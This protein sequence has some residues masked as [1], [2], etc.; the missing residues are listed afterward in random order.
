[1]GDVPR[2]LGLSIRAD[3]LSRH[4]AFT[5]PS[6]HQHVFVANTRT[7]LRTNPQV[8]SQVLTAYQESGSYRPIAN[9]YVRFAISAAVPVPASF[10]TNRSYPHPAHSQPRH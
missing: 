6:R 7:L 4:P 9:S 2:H 5:K 8:A 1:V 10:P 3:G